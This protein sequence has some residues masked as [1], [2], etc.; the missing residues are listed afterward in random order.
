MDELATTQEQMGAFL[1]LF[2]QCTGTV[3]SALYYAGILCGLIVFPIYAVILLRRHTRKYMDKV[4]SEI[5]A[6]DP[7]LWATLRGKDM[8]ETEKPFEWLQD[9]CQWQKR[10]HRVRVFFGSP[11]LEGKCIQATGALLNVFLSWSADL[12]DLPAAQKGRLVTLLTELKKHAAE[13]DIDRLLTVLT[14]PEDPFAWIRAM[15]KAAR[16]MQS[17]FDFLAGVG[18]PADLTA[19]AAAAY[20]E[21]TREKTA[22]ALLVLARDDCPFP[23]E[24]DTFLRGTH[25]RAAGPLRIAAIHVDKA[26]G[27]DGRLVDSLKDRLEGSPHLRRLREH[28]AW[29]KFVVGFGK[30]PLAA[31]EGRPED[32]AAALRRRR[33]TLVAALSA[34]PAHDPATVRRRKEL[35]LA[36]DT[37]QVLLEEGLL[38]LPLTGSG[39]QPPQPL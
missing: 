14:A 10:Y 20:G 5:S 16:E 38:R 9:L 11:D 4:L 25:A 23:V 21:A 27:K 6:R 33:Q 31:L 34:A 15:A 3:T 24:I 30:T 1:G 2:H 22:M 8:F 12:R 19:A 18:L 39:T 7:W 17:W 29:H 13:P 32:D 28:P 26:L 36:W 37:L 35:D